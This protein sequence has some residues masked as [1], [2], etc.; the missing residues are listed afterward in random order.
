V[1]K[2]DTI[3]NIAEKFKMNWKFLAKINKLTPP[4][5]IKEDQTILVKN[6]KLSKQK[7]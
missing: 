5:V 2:N 3:I 7:A 6:S 1:K 4:F